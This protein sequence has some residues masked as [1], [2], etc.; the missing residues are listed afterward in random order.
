M[1]KN[2]LLLLLVFAA[3]HAQV[4]NSNFEQGSGYGLE[5]VAAWGQPF[6]FPITLNTETGEST[7]DEIT[8]GGPTIGSFCTSV[9]DPHSGERA[10]LIR[11]AFNVTANKVIPGKASLFN[12]AISEVPSSWNL[13]I[14]VEPNADIQ[15]LSFWYKFLPVGNDV[16]EAKLEL[17]NVDGE[18]IGVAKL[19]FSEP[20]YNYVSAVVPLVITL[21]DTP[22]FM[23]IDF[24]MAAEDSEPAFGSTLII[25]DVAVNPTALQT[26]QFQS[27]SFSVWPTVA[28]SE[29]NVQKNGAAG[30]HNFKIINIEGKTI[31][32]N[33]LEL[34]SGIPAKLDVSS[35]SSGFYILKSDN[36]YTAKFIKK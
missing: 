19:Q 1:K 12:T 18:S 28:N 22:A 34:Q 25:D 6:L 24:S 33:R 31:S 3:A 30:N 16:A 26:A 10:M 15:F 27:D 9:Q 5:N 21:D 7:A 17:F 29:I 11:N 20:K 4:P 2:Y 23:T 13:G 14:P 32:E 8:F 35:L 36:G